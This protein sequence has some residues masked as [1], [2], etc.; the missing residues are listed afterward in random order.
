MKALGAY[1]S[2]K[3]EEAWKQNFQEKI[4]KI[5]KLTENWSFRRLSLLGKVTLIKTLLASQL[6]YILTPLPTCHMA[7]RPGQV[8][9]S[10]HGFFFEIFRVGRSEKNAKK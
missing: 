2:T 8:N 10:K 9:F 6:V 7:I 5:R 4:E 3:A 1:F